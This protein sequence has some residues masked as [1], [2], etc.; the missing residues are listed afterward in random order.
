MDYL[1]LLRRLK[2]CGPAPVRL[3]RALLIPVSRAEPSPLLDYV[4]AGCGGSFSSY[5][6]VG[7]VA[8]TSLDERVVG[9]EEEV[10]RDILL[11]HRR[12]RSVYAKRG[13]VGEYRVADLV[14]IGGVDDPV[15]IYREAGLR[16][17]VDVSRVYVNPR[18]ST[19]HVRLSSELEGRVLDMFAGFGGFSV[20]AACMESVEL[21]VANDINPAAVE[22]L[23]RSLALNKARLR[24][25][26]LVL[27]MDAA[28]LPDVLPHGFFDHIIMN[29]PHASLDFIPAARL[30]AAPGGVLHVYLVASSG[31]EAREAVES[32]GCRVIGSRRVIDYAPRRYI[33]RVDAACD[34][35]EDGHH[36]GEG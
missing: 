24:A 11:R 14:L 19:E 27:R 33:Y 35:V 4:V 13:T 9:C 25:P 34:V 10:A 3:G 5:V 31:S 29:L 36:P 32:R 16:F 2:L 30:L 17:Y 28:R 21:V 6:L 26:V 12:V 18:L 22:C 1:G 23:V 7:E 20:R 15:T 8:L